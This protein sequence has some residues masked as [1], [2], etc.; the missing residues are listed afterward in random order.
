M[1]KR[2]LTLDLLSKFQGPFK[3]LTKNAVIIKMILLQFDYKWHSC[4]ATAF[5]VN[6]YSGQLLLHHAHQTSTLSIE[7]N[8]S[9]TVYVYKHFSWTLLHVLYGIRISQ[10]PPTHHNP[11][12][13]GDSCWILIVEIKR[14]ADKLLCGR[15][16]V[17][18]LHQNKTL[19]RLSDMHL[20]THFYV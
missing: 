9:I 16:Y 6:L 4:Y 20:R 5:Q 12:L 3:L 10:W 11:T 19:M 2:P 15:R 7:V 17:C 18:I 13:Q 1:S 8:G 14:C